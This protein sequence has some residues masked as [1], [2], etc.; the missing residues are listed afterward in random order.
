MYGSICMQVAAGE[1]VI[2]WAATPDAAQSHA[3]AE[4]LKQLYALAWPS[5]VLLIRTITRHAAKLAAGP[6]AVAAFGDRGADLAQAQISMMQV[7]PN[8]RMQASADL[9]QQ[10]DAG[11]DSGISSAT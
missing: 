2:A 6:L 9:H 11:P 7:Q 4:A 1:A 10:S 3:V 8:S 5:N